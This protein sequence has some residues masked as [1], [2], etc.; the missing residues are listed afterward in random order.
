MC[1][2]Y[3]FESHLSTHAAHTTYRVGLTDLITTETSAV[4]AATGAHAIALLTEWDEFAS[5]DYKGQ[6]DCCK[7]NG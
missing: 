7:V 6:C 5:L 4:V 3:H 1:R 2:L